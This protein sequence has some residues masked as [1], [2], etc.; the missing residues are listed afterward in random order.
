V[1]ARPRLKA[2][3]LVGA[4]DV[5]VGLE[6]GS[7]PDAVIQVENSA[8]LRLEVCC[9]REDPALVP[10]GAEHVVGEPALDGGTAE[11]GGKPA[12]HGFA[13]ELPDTE[14]RKGNACFAGS[15][16]ASAST[17]YDESWG[18][19]SG[20]SAA[21]L[22][23][24]TFEPELAEALSPFADDLPRH[25]ELLADELVVEPL[26]REQDELGADYLGI[27]CRVAPGS[28]FELLPFL[29]GEDDDARTRLGHAHLRQRGRSEH[30]PQVNEV[31]K[32]RP[33]IYGTGH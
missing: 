6:G 13:S 25:V 27:G 17:F 33:C 19:S 23:G 26:S 28:G 4:D 11:R 16:Q 5:L 7:L 9:T 8:G 24:E 30:S 2:G 3:L 32:T 18:K 21:W 20:A 31:N 10:P 1:K 22:V 14:S 15:S 12:K 29:L